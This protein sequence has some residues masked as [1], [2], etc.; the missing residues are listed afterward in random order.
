MSENNIGF[1]SKPHEWFEAFLPCSLVSEW[2]TF[3]NLK[4]S[5]QHAGNKGGPYQD[6][7]KDFEPFELKSTLESTYPRGYHHHPKLS[8][9]FGPSQMM[10]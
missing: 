3:T 9:S 2:T 7:G 6:E 1:D 4:A 5:F 10:S 8:L